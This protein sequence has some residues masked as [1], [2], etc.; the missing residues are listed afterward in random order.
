MQIEGGCKKTNIMIL[1]LRTAGDKTHITFIPRHKAQWH[2]YNALLSPCIDCICRG[3]E[4]GK[5]GHFRK[6]VPLLFLGKVN[7][8][9][10]FAGGKF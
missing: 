1:W 4:W 2:S 6:E 9:G 10:I 8:G 3:R 5:Q 7:T